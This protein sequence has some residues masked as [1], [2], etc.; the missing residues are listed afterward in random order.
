MALLDFLSSQNLE[1]L[2]TLLRW[3][4]LVFAA[5]PLALA[6]YL[7]RS[8][9]K[10]LELK[11]YSHFPQPEP[12]DPVRGHWPW[13]EKAAGEGDPRRQFD[14]M[15]YEQA[16]KLGFPPVLLVDWRPIEKFPILFVLDNE[17]AEQVT[18]P[19]KS[20]RT[21]M[22]KHPAIQQLAPL[23]G[24][25]SLVTTDGDEW[26]ALY[27][28]IRPGFQ[29]NHLLGLVNVI[30][31]KT[32]TF[33]ELMEQEAAAG[34]TFRLESYT[35]NLVFDI[36]GIV[37]FDMDL[38]AQI[39]GKQSEV[40]LTY[41]ALSQA[42][43]K[44]PFGGVGWRDYFSANER[45]IRSKDKR[46]DSIL[47]AEIKRQHKSLLS[48]STDTKTKNK[49]VATL[50]LHGIDK[51]TPQVL[52]QTSD[53]LRGFLFAGHDTTSILL[54][55]AFYELH[56]HPSAAQ[57][58]SEE[59][60][61]VFGS[62]TH[63]STVANALRGADAGILLNKL[64]YTD[65]LIKETL[66]LHPPGTT[67]RVAPAAS[68]TTLTLPDGDTLCIDGICVT[69][70]AY[71]IQRHPKTFG[72]TRNDFKPERWIGEEGKKIPESAFRPYERG[73]RRCTGSEL[74]NLETK[75]IIACAARHFDFVKQGLGE[76]DLDEKGKVQVDKK[77]RAKTKGIMFSTHQVTAK[78]VD[79]MEI[80]VQVKGSDT[81][82]VNEAPQIVIIG[83]LNTGRSS[84]ISRITFCAAAAAAKFVNPAVCPPLCEFV[85]ADFAGLYFYPPTFFNISTAWGQRPK[86]QSRNVLVGFVFSRRSQGSCGL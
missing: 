69:P 53:T 83:R 52:Q 32:E 37:T 51:L 35:T 58:L 38:N 82:V 56:I 45:E 85:G 86:H 9:A 43:N 75:I 3:E 77:G 79:G 19:N 44:R 65:A 50:S 49:S 72:D 17:V 55:W 14:E 16:E 4:L 7:R 62:D 48:G 80:K 34:E 26:N 66:R 76:L 39:D 84:T 28:R 46:L 68:N 31:D 33:V 73:P 61:S 23:V 22:P 10:P 78:P 36:I 8:Q 25:R 59:L 29:P 63:H 42:F 20:F 6:Y 64:H 40:L 30:V 2:G 11:Q 67:A 60:D 15:L 57:T 24:A 74:A 41:R 47:K 27:K 13:I 81:R 71:T 1:T 54:Q 70:R 12:A 18:K 5:I 21:S